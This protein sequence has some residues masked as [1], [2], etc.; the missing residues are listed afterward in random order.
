M[1]TKTTGVPFRRKGGT[2]CEVAGDWAQALF[3]L[4]DSFRGRFGPLTI[5]A[6]ELPPGDGP[7]TEQI[8]VTM[9]EVEDG[10][11][12]VS[13]GSTTWRTRQFWGSYRRIR[14][15]CEQLAAES[16]V[17]HAGIN[18]L[19]QPYS[20]VGFNAARR[21]DKTTVFVLDGDE[22]QRM[23]DLHGTDPLRLRVRHAGYC[24]VYA[25]VAAK[26]VARADLALLKGQQLHQRYGRWARNAKD[27]FD[28]SFH[29]SD[30]VPA[31]ELE[32]KCSA[33]LAGGP[34]RCLSL[35][36]LVGYKGVD[37]TL[38]AIAAAVGAGADV[39]LDVIGDGPA[40]GELSALAT[41]LGIRERVEFKGAR[42]YGPALL[43]EIAQSHVLLFTSTAEETPRSLFDGLA[44]GCALLAFDLPFTRQV[45]AQ[46]GHGALVERG[47]HIE[48]AGL[49]QSIDR[50][51]P[52]LVGWMK[53][54]AKRAREQSVE[55]W[56]ERRAQWTIEAYERHIRTR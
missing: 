5:A 28:T 54:A 10:I 18:N 9:S 29:D 8:T 16:D 52:R 42:P 6:P 7:I 47:K 44:G 17:L 23:R 32:R 11:R 36:R 50:D 43:R 45:V 26:A 39:R 14:K 21:K 31:A 34:V 1:Y 49:I 38:R 35:G 40:L 15:Q 20:L 27:F 2:Q 13:L 53:T 30:I 56:Y 19:W 22:I 33:T 12:F 46:L 3:L 37:H 25:R 41:T 48:L 55:V 51:R 4:R 24:A